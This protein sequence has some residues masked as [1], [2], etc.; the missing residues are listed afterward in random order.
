LPQVIDGVLPDKERDWDYTGHC[1][2]GLIPCI[3]PDYVRVQNYLVG[4]FLTTDSIRSFSAALLV[5]L[6]LLTGLLLF[7]CLVRS[8]SLNSGLRNLTSKN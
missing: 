3:P 5:K 6:L 2:I 7:N 4:T 1:G 8:E